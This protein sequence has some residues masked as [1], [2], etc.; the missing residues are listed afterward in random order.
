MKLAPVP[1]MFVPTSVEGVPRFGV[2]STGEVAKTSAPVPVSSVTAE[3]RFALE[4]VPRK[5]AIPVPSPETPVLIGRPVEVVRVRVSLMYE[6]P[7]VVDAVTAPLPFVVR[8]P[9]VAYE[10]VSPVAIVG[11]ARSDEVAK[12]SEPVPVS[13]VTIAASSAEVSMSALFVR[14]TSATSALSSA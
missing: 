4:G 6:S 9:P 12:T 7:I 14:V 13:F 11:E 2:V 10:R 8:T 1:V 5:V 3:I